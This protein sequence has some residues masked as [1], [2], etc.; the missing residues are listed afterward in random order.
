MQTDKI[1]TAAVLPP[2][3]PLTMSDAAREG[4]SPGMMRSHEAVGTETAL[5]QRYVAC[6]VMTAEGSSAP[7]S[8]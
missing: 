8:T 7:C 6:A 5:Q 1:R 3:P 4:L 2:P